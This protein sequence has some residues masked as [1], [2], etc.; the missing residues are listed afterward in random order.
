MDI[1]LRS[2]ATGAPSSMQIN[3]LKGFA[4]HKFGLYLDSKDVKHIPSRRNNPQTN[5]KMER[6]F[7]VWEA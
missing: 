5:G 6:W 7:K 2:T 4:R 3:V 1:S